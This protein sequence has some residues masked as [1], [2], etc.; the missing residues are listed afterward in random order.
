MFCD[1]YMAEEKLNIQDGFS[2]LIDSRVFVSLLSLYWKNKIRLMRSP[3]CVC[4]CVCVCVGG[5]GG[6]MAYP[7]PVETFEWLNQSLWNLLIWYVYQG[8]WAH[9][10]GIILKSLSSVIPTLQPCLLYVL[11]FVLFPLHVVFPCLYQCKIYCHWVNTQ[12]QNNNNR[13]MKQTIMLLEHLYQSSWN[14]VHEAISMAY[15]IKPFDQ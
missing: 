2:F 7:P 4:V 1:L 15:F 6:C 3:W 5:G 13:F 11:F 8:T 10:N 14:L 12:L 9:L